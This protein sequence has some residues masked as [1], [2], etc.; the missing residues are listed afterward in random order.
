MSYPSY[1]MVPANS[2]PDE[3]FTIFGELSAALDKARK[4]AEMV[5]AMREA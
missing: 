2:T 4:D 1:F 5:K 3:I